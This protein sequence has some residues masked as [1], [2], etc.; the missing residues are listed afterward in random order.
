VFVGCGVSVGLGVGWGGIVGLTCVALNCVGNCAG[1]T[2]GNKSL[3]ATRSAWRGGVVSMV[4]IKT[5]K[6]PKT[7]TPS[8]PMIVHSFLVI[9][10]LLVI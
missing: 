4:S 1:V 2:D 7:A 3:T 8:T 6:H 9:G 5:P 10:N